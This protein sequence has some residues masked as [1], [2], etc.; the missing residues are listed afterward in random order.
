MTAKT[1]ALEYM[2]ITIRDIA[3]LM[4]IGI[5]KACEIFITF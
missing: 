3:N 1:L 4:G 5:G 2:S